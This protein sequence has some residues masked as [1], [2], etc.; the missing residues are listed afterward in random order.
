MIPWITIE[1]STN[2]VLNT[3]LKEIA[4]IL[5][6]SLNWLILLFYGFLCLLEF[7]VQSVYRGKICEPVMA[8]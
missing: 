1:N 4:I 7:A 6:I 5:I 3:M 2:S 8:L